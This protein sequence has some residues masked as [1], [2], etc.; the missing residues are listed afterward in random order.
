MLHSMTWYKTA[1]RIKYHQ[2]GRNFHDLSFLKTSLFA[3]HPVFQPGLQTGVL[4]KTG[5]GVGS[6]P[7][8]NA[9]SQFGEKTSFVGECSPLHLCGVHIS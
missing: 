6:H 8:R 4:L 3:L 7:Q 9:G 2:P 1:V 5:W